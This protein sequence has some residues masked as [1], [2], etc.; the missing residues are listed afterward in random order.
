MG[1]PAV[2]LKGPTVRFSLRDS[3]AASVPSTERPNPHADADK[4]DSRHQ[5]PAQRDTTC[6]DPMPAFG[7][8]SSD[9]GQHVLGRS[10]P[11]PRRRVAPFTN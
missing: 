10:L 11:R 5:K 7:D 4:A 3:A 1:C 9:L 6:R 2:S 8:R